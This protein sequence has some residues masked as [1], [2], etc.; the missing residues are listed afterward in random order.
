[1]AKTDRNRQKALRSF[2]GFCERVGFEPEPFQKRIAGAFFGPEREFLAL[3][4]R[5]NGKSRL[6]GALAVHHL[7]VIPDARVYVAAA[8][9][10]QASVIHEY[11]RDFARAADPDIDINLREIR[12]E[13]GYLRIVASDAGKLQGLTPSLVIVDE[14]HAAK[15]LPRVP[16][17]VAPQELALG[18]GQDSSA[19]PQRGYCPP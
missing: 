7:F 8:S 2:L 6:A 11:A 16:M 15:D 19:S 18:A 3:L 5:G 17:V 13:T 4:P 9:R 12:T 10:E 1:M 14:L